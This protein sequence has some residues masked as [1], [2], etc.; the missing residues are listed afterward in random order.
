MGGI[1]RERGEGEGERVEVAPGEAI[2]ERAETRGW[3]V[4]RSWKRAGRASAETR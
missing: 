1:E 2:G 4:M 3:E